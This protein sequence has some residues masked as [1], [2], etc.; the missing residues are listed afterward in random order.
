MFTTSGNGHSSGFWTISG[1]SS[2]GDTSNSSVIVNRVGTDKAWTGKKWNTVDSWRNWFSGGFGANK[3]RSSKEWCTI[4]GRRNWLG[5]GLGG[6]KTGS[7]EKRCTI[8]SGCNG[9][10]LVSK[11][12][13]KESSKGD[14]GIFHSEW[15]GIIDAEHTAVYIAERATEKSPFGSP[16]GQ[17]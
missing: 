12:G 3:V 6:H 16:F 17:L 13:S 10:Q 8:N 11:D 5:G 14:G 9:S 1:V 15:N 4:N 2:N 7:C